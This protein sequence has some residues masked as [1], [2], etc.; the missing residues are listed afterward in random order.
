MEKRSVKKAAMVSLCAALAAGQVVY[1]APDAPEDVYTPDESTSVAD[2]AVAGVAATLDQYYQAQ[3][4]MVDLS[5][6]TGVAGVS[7]ALD[8]YYNAYATGAVSKSV[9]LALTT[10][11]SAEA[12]SVLDNY[13]NLGI[14]NVNSYLNVRKEPKKNGEIIGKM[15][16]FSGCEIL[17]DAGDWYKIKS[18]PVTG[19]VSK[20]YILT[21]EDAELIAVQEARLR[22]IVTTESNLN[23]RK[24]P[25]ADSKKI[26]K[27]TTDERYDVLNQVNGWI[28]ISLEGNDDGKDM[29]SGFISAD[30]A[31]VKYALIEAYEF[32]PVT[33]SSSL[34]NSVV[35]YALQF[36]GNRYVWGGTSLTKGADCSGFTMS[37]YKNF[38]ISLTHSSRAQANQ[39]KKISS[40]EMKPG[41]LIFYGSGRINHVA[42]Y[43]GN[44]QIVHAANPS[45]GIKISRWN[46]T[47]PV[48]IV[49]VIGD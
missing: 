21:G 8:G 32:S 26:T 5:D 42:M 33:S 41:D 19:Y 1:A 45:A 27:I 11:T 47:T 2:V 28:E 20:E 39:G 13:T 23:V 44:G 10:M 18:G 4:S 30:Y 35:N 22:A 49:N 9:A 14:A 34:R 31:E 24:E 7:V 29:S 36:L 25:S 40:S 12:A 37:V 15:I 38:G 6:G 48:K 3:A 43:I 17:E 46:Y 16:R